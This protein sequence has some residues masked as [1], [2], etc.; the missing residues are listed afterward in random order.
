MVHI[1]MRE[2]LEEE[3]AEMK[4]LLCKLCSDVFG[5][6]Y[7]ERACKCGNAKGRYINDVTAVYSGD[8]AVPIGFNSFTLQGAVMNQPEYGRGER[9]DAFVIPKHSPTMKKES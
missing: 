2:L 8:N 3:E 4:L 1:I 6:D 5:L 7:A 9:F